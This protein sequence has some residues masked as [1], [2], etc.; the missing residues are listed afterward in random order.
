VSIRFG[1]AAVGA[2]VALGGVGVFAATHVHEIDWGDVPTWLATAFAGIA[3]VFA[4]RAIA[5]EFG[6]ERQAQA[7]KVGVWSVDGEGETE[8]HFALRNAS[9]LPVYETSVY[10]FDEDF[11]ETLVPVLQVFLGALAPSLEPVV[12]PT[13]AGEPSRRYRYGVAFTDAAGK[14]WHRDATGR[15]REG[16]LPSEA[17]FTVSESRV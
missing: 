14:A 1:V 2:A 8:P 16:E 11:D 13:A 17:G 3:A 7:S 5:L 6:R 4:Y 15:L 10:V 12:W 9:E